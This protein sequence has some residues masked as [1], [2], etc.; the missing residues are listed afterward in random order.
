MK[1]LL[2]RIAQFVKRVVESEEVRYFAVP[3]WRPWRDF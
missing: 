1:I 2:D 3:V